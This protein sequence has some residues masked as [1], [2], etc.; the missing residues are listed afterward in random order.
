MDLNI[1]ICEES[2]PWM[3]DGVLEVG[4]EGVEVAVKGICVGGVSSCSN[5]I[6]NEMMIK[7]QRILKRVQSLLIYFCRSYLR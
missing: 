2:V 3:F 6:I 5:P 7:L 4:R 1:Q